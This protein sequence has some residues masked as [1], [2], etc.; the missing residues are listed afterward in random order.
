MLI[1]FILQ[2]LY[3]F[4]DM[5]VRNEIID[6]RAFTAFCE[7]KSPDKVPDGDMIGRFRNILVQHDMRKKFLI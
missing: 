2:N 5:N 3:D 4:N 7:I 1:N 6:S